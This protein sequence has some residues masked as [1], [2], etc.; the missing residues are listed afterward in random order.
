ME[1]LRRFSQVDPLA[2]I[3][4][5]GDS[6]TDLTWKG[7]FARIGNTVN[8]Y[9]SADE[10]V[11]NG[12]DGVNEKLTRRYAW[13]NQEMAKGGYLVSFSP[14]AGWAF[15]DHYLTQYVKGHNH[16]DPVYGYRPFSA[17]LAAG[18]AP[19]N[20]MERPLFRDF[21]DSRIYGS[22]GGDFLRGNAQYKWR[23]LAYGIP[24]ESFATGANEVEAWARTGTGNGMSKKSARRNVNMAM[25]CGNGV[26]PW[27]HSYFVQRPFSMTHKLYEMLV[28]QI[29][30]AARRKR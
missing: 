13:Y 19:T 30:V 24:T 4:P 29:G 10:V 14:E 1:T 20:L 8:F 2:W 21:S 7:L 12:H 3:V 28:E 27:T 11:A 9:S 16:G 15:G 6:R 26:T 18:I 5:P 23:V 17:G 25:E 22:D